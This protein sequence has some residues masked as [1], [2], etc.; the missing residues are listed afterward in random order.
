[1][2]GRQGML[3]VTTTLCPSLP[4]TRIMTLPAITARQ[5]IEVDGGST[6]ASFLI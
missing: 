5:F 2:V 3:S 6:L 4:R 1:M